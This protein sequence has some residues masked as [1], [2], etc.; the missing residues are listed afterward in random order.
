MMG[1][2]DVLFLFLAVNINWCCFCHGCAGVAPLSKCLLFAMIESPCANWS[3]S[4]LDMISTI[5]VYTV[6][7]KNLKP[8]L[9]SLYFSRK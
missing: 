9:V 8:P 3:S 7:C 1:K 4:C 5:R 6:L 2:C